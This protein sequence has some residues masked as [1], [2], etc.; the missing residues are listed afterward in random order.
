MGAPTQATGTAAETPAAVTTNGFIGWS[1]EASR[2]TY[3][4]ASSNKKGAAEV[5]NTATRAKQ[6]YR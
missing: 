5:T 1:P 3:T 6:F 4:V 2:A